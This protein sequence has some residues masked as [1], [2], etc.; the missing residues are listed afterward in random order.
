MIELKEFQKS[1]ADQIAERFAKYYEEP[2]MRGTTKQPARR[3]VLPER[4]P[5]SPRRARP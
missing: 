5:R 2:P 1:A 4:S 3:A